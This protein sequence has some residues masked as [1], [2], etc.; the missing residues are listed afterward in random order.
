MNYLKLEE[1]MKVFHRLT[2]KGPGFCEV[3]IFPTVLYNVPPPP[4]VSIYFFVTL[5]YGGGMGYQPSPL[6]STTH[7]VPFYYQE[8]YVDKHQG[9]KNWEP[10]KVHEWYPL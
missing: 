2:K 9:S 10:P 8:F 1:E 5:S 7:L 4:F 3:A 6:W